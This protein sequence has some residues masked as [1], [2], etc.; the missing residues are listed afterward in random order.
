MV[1]PSNTTNVCLPLS[2]IP[3]V[4]RFDFICKNAKKKGSTTESA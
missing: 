2:S 3:T 1:L 4:M